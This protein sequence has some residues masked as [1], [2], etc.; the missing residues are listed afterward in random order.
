[1]LCRVRISVRLALIYM[2]VFAGGLAAGIASPTVAFYVRYELGGQ[3]IVAASLTSGFMLGR[4]LASTVSGVVSEIYPSAR[5]YIVLLGLFTIGLTAGLLVPALREPLLVVIV[6]GFWGL[7]AGLIWPSM[8][9]VTA[10][11]GKERSGGAL[12]IYFALGGLGITLGNMLFGRLETGTL[13]LLR[14]SAFLYILSGIL[15]YTGVPS[16]LNIPSSH[17]SERLKASLRGAL[18][19]PA[20]W[21]ILAAFSL[22]YLNGLL[23]EYF[24]LYAHEHFG[25]TKAQLGDT[26]LTGGMAG[27]LIGLIV[28]PLSD[29]WGIHRMLF[30]VL[31]ITGISGLILPFSSSYWILVLSYTGAAA[32]VRGSMPLTRNRDIVRGPGG[33]LAV[34]FSNTASSMG[35]TI[36][37]IVAGAIYDYTRSLLFIP[38]LSAAILVIVVAIVGLRVLRA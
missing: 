10:E 8:Q 36:S 19:A 26:L 4:G 12:S 25:L 33:A 24:Y 28:G 16:M 37:P 18:S 21:V 11:L 3:M 38:Y 34:G 15:L 27:V 14:L 1:M 29:R 32:G 5:R 31:L 9:I 30:L 35:M 23:R 22:G 20:L 2:G 6:T 13:G 17:R 7:L